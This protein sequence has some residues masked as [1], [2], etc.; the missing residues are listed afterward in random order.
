[1]P[2][3]FLMCSHCQKLSLVADSPKH[4]AQKL[5][6]HPNGIEPKT[7]DF[8]TIIQKC[9][10]FRELVG[11]A[12]DLYIIHPYMLH[13]SSANHSG[14][15]R[16]M[17]NPPVVLREPL[18]LDQNRSDLSLLEETTLRFLGTNFPPPPESARVSYWWE[19]A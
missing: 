19:V 4:V 3:P 5:L 8:P 2:T 10:D 13:A 15:P 14:R 1:M 16:V 12:G 11:K 9:H 6:E 17:S 18:R 7:F